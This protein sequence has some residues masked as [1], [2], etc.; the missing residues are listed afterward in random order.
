MVAISCATFMIGPFSPPSAAARSDAFLPRSSAEAE[1]PARGELRRDAAHIGADARIARRAG[2]EAVFFAIRHDPT[3]EISK[4]APSANEQ[5]VSCAA[6]VD[7]VPS[8]VAAAVKNA[9]DLHLAL[10]RPV[11]IKNQERSDDQDSD[12]G[13]ERAAR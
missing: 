13:S 8:D 6:A 9:E 5:G 2:G 12:L 7:E 11:V 3:T 1:Q 10:F 4:G